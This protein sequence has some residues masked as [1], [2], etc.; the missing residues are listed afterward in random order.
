MN[1]AERLTVAFLALLDSTLNVITLGAWSR[2]Q[3]SKQASYR[4]RER[5]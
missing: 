1:A 5:S 3:G 4:I 2:H